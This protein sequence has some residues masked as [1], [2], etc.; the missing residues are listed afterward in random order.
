MRYDA[1]LVLVL[2]AVAY[3]KIMLQVYQSISLALAVFCIS[4]AFGIWAG[5]ES[6]NTPEDEN[7]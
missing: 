6:G 4:G 3:L 2:A 1:I 7:T 5:L